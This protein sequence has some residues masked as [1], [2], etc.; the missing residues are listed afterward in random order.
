MVKRYLLAGI[1]VVSFG[2]SS[3]LFGADAKV[4]L[5][6][7]TRTS[8]FS[9]EDSNGNTVMRAGGN[10]RVGIGTAV[11]SALLHLVGVTPVLRIDATSG[12]GAVFQ[13]ARS[14]VEDAAI[15]GGD[16]LI[17]REGGVV[18]GDIIFKV[19]TN[20]ERLRITNS[21]NVGIGTPNPLGK[22]DVNGAIF[23]RGASLHADYVF[24]DDY[25]LESI[26]SHSE[27]MWQEKHLKAIPKAL[28]DKNGLE[29]VEV[30]AHRKGIVEELEKAHI[31]IGQL[32][33]KNKELEDKNRA[34][35]NR[36]AKLEGI[37]NDLAD[38]M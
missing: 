22:L 13:L 31:Y 23:Q 36:L 14:E 2:M 6:D 1:V 11:P 27:F 8:G 29:I 17:I 38:K 21:G 26:E 37:I 32:H 16:D 34:I 18:A 19:R 3:I 30:G 35:E 20:I 24:A 28:S 5:E 7:S 4:T 12:G 33:G 10:G 15:L 25:K 9:V